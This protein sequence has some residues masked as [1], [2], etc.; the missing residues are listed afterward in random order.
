MSGIELGCEFWCSGPSGSI[1]AD[2]RSSK[3][4]DS[5]LCVEAGMIQ[6]IPCHSC[7]DFIWFLLI[8]DPFSDNSSTTLQLIS[9]W[10]MSHGMTSCLESQCFGHQRGSNFCTLLK[11]RFKFTIF[12][13]ERER[14]QRRECVIFFSVLLWTDT[15]LNAIAFHGLLVLLTVRRWSRGG[16]C[17]PCPVVLLFEKNALTHW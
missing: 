6:D 15:S 5:R 13:R 3:G 1:Y 4:W 12:Q 17:L 7:I 9:G 10:K 11:H 16:I 8:L 14:G 2:W